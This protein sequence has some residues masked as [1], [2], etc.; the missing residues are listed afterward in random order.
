[1]SKEEDKRIKIIRCVFIDAN[2]SYEVQMSFTPAEYEAYKKTEADEKK[3]AEEKK[4]KDQED[5]DA[6]YKKMLADNNGSDVIIV[7]DMKEQ[8]TYPG[9][10]EALAS[11]RSV[12]GYW[13]WDRKEKLEKLEYYLLS[14]K[15][16][17]VIS[18]ADMTRYAEYAEETPEDLIPYCWLREKMGALFVSDKC[19]RDMCIAL[20]QKLPTFDESTRWKTVVSVHNGYVKT[21][22][23]ALMYCNND[24]T[25]KPQFKYAK[26]STQQQQKED[27]APTT[28][29]DEEEDN[30]ADENY[31][32]EEEE[33]EVSD[34]DDEPEVAQ[35]KKKVRKNPSKSS[36][37]KG[38][39]KKRAKRI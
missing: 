13:Y 11:G 35:P 4:K 38:K 27:A 18:K 19:T 26:S 37:K 22:W 1:M 24:G 29:D 10:Y 20:E 33:E 30:E 6:E 14:G 39:K 23:E 15:P 34:D 2:T 21:L 28:S 36:K 5:R 7:K 25:L 8:W 16:P 17:S 3:A 12:K 9:D 32:E 31:E